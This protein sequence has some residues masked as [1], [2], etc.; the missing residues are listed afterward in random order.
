[1]INDLIL[2]KNNIMK[3]KEIFVVL[4]TALIVWD[5]SV[6]AQAPDWPVSSNY[7]FFWIS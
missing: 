4:L 2:M 5:T 7:V 1:M 6:S 3:R